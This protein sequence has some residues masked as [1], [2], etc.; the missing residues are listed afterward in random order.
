MLIVVARPRRVFVSHTSELAR[1]PVGRS[2]VA[3]A[4]HAVAR[5]G[6]A[7]VEMAYFGPRNQQPAQVCTE[8]VRA[9]DVYVAVVGFRYGSPVTDRPELS[10]TELEFA[11]ASETNLPRLVLLIGDDAEGPKDLFMDLRYGARQEAFRARL[12]KSGLTTATVTTPEALSE[13]LFQ[14]LMQLSGAGLERAAV[15]RVWNVPARSSMFTG[16]EQLL[17]ALRAAL[18]DEKRSTAVVH[19]LY[20]IGGIGKTA[21]ATEYAHRYG[22]EYDVVWWVPAEQP[23]LAADRLAELAQALGVA[24][25]TDPVTAAVGRLLGV[26]RQRHRWLLVFDNAEDPAALA[27]Y[28]PGG[29]GHVLIT[30]RNPGWQELAIPVEVDVFDRSESIALL[31]RRAPRLTDSEAERVAE[32][33]G[34]LPLALAQAAAQLADTATLVQDYLHLVVQRTAELMAQDAPVTYP[35]SLA[36]S[37]QIALD[38]LGAQSPA[39]LMLLTLAAYLAPEPIPLT[40]FSSHAAT[41]PDPLASVATDPLAFTALTRLLRR[42]GLG[43]VEPATLQ[44]HRLLAAILRSQ[45]NP[46]PDS[47]ILVVRLLRAAVPDDD[48]L[49][50]PPVWPAWRQLLPHVLVATDPHHNFAGIEED[51]A[52][53]LERAARY[54]GDR[55]EP[56][57]AQPLLERA[58]DLRRCLL[59]EDHPDTLESA[60][61]LSL[62]L[63]SLGQYEQ[64]RQLGGD[65]LTR[66][67][68]VLGED[69]PDTL[70]SAKFLS[71]NLWSLGQYEQARQ[72]GGDTLTRCRRVLGENHPGTLESAVVFSVILRESGQYERARQLGEDTLTR[73]RRVLGEDH[74]HTLRTAY[75]LAR[76]LQ[77]LGLYEPARRLGEDTLARCQ[78][79]QG[80]DHPDTLFSAVVLVAVLRELGQYERARLLSEDTLARYHRVQGEDHLDTL[81]SAV[82]LA[83]TLR[84][85]GQYERARQVGEDALTRCRRVLGEDHPNTLRAAT[86]LAATLRKL[87]Q[88]ECSRQL[89]ENTLTRIRHVLGEDHPDTICLAHG[90]AAVLVD[91]GEA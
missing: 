7:I 26:L 59:G 28:L 80:D 43:R 30:S 73:C 8:A 89:G 63:W 2:F 27:R 25:A 9:A 14:A 15:G 10:Y 29:G 70:E 19:A 22:A 24:N 34:D 40:L 76:T 57:P 1:F 68:R 91:L 54:L 87:G 66:C 42:H 41:L 17:A 49:S 38:R 83:D 77:E 39:A 6:D 55:G 79:F 69:H 60:N 85:S 21:L 67:R 64:A 44:L 58:W 47:P 32:A 12:S 31:R 75:N 36:A 18:Q 74:P 62:N 53:L 13:A 35:V 81:F 61:S 78:R 11:T 50:N 65:T 33:L 72:L 5:A 3:A 56:D 51:Q 46:Q 4:Q 84:E 45:P 37:T 90:L 16:R 23:A 52:W 88:Y 71:L 20:G 82:V 48:P 86:S